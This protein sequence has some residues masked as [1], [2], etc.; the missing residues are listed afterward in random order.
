MHQQDYIYHFED[1]NDRPR[2]QVHVLCPSRKSYT[3]QLSVDDSQLCLTRRQHVPAL[4]ADCLDLAVAVAIADRLTLRKADHTRHIHVRL[5]VRHPEIFSRAQTQQ[6]LLSLLYWYTHDQWSFEFCSRSRYGRLAERQLHLPFAS[7]DDCPPEVALWSGGLDSLAGLYHN[8]S[9]TPS[10]TYTLFGTGMNG[11]IHKKQRDCALCIAH[12]FPKRTTFIQLPFW[13]DETRDIPKNKL[14]RSRGFVFLLLG[15]VCALLE[16]QHMLSIYENGIGAINL[17]YC[18]AEV[19][20]DHSLAVHPVSLL[21]MSEF[22]SSLIGTT[23]AFRNPFLFHTKAQ[24][25]ETLV[26]AGGR[27]LVPMTFTCDGPHREIPLQ[28]GYCS[29][30]LLRRQAL[31]ILGVED[32]TA[33]IS[34]LYQRDIRPAYRDSLRTMHLQVISLRECLN[35]ADP[36]TFLLERHPSLSLPLREIVDEMGGDKKALL[37]EQLLLLYRRYIYEWEQVYPIVGQELLEGNRPMPL[38]REH[39]AKGA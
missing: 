20:L 31:A 14:Q 29:S 26:A 3:A 4:L 30:C 24:L 13:L 8:L 15:A 39:I 17:P 6:K 7:S 34:T 35:T 25:C 12:Q 32:Q 38:A 36:W 19:G 1:L 28:C 23:F 2:S 10:T 18:D 27:D 33:Y 21:R 9:S 5:P 16:S 11:M 22:I 37:Q